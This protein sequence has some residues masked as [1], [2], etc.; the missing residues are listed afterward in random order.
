MTAIFHDMM[1]QEL[2][3]YVD[4][5][6]VKSKKRGEHFYVEICQELKTDKFQLRLDTRM[7]VDMDFTISGFSLLF[8]N[9][10]AWELLA[11]MSRSHNNVNNHILF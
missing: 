2:E 9:A 1:H 5:I 7:V 8:T 10:K 6:V 4:D 11:Y 3:D